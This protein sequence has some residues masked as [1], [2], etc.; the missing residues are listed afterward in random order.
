[1]GIKQPGPGRPCDE[2]HLHELEIGD[3]DDNILALVEI[4]I[5]DIS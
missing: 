5:D 1:M 4:D 2:V 3:D